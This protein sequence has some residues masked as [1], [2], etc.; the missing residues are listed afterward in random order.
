M[1]QSWREAWLERNKKQTYLPFYVVQIAPFGEWLGN[2]GSKFVKIREQQELIAD[3]VPDNYLISSSDVGNIF[4]IHPKNKKV[5]AERLYQLVDHIDFGNP[6]PAYA[7][8]AKKLNVEDGKVIIQIEHCH[9]LVK[10]ERNFES[11]NGF[12]LEEIPELFIPPITDG[13]NGLEIIV[14]GITHK[15]VKVNLIANHIIIESP[16]IVPSR[17]IK[18]NFA[19]TAFYEVN[20]YN[21]LHHPMMP[22]ALSN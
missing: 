21:E 10:E 19:K 22:F 12:E 2:E 5:L 16:A 20:I 17:D 9:Q 7:P 3:S 14:D 4:D 8:R 15:N 11:Y 18:I 6:L 1:V 13:I